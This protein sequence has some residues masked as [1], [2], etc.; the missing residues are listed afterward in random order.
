[1]KNIPNELRAAF[2][3]HFVLPRFEELLDSLAHGS[4]Y[5]HAGD[6]MGRVGIFHGY[7]THSHYPEMHGVTTTLLDSGF[8][9]HRCDFP[10]HGRSVANGC[11]KERGQIKS[12]LRL[13][14]AVHGVTYKTLTTK[15]KKTLPVF[16]VGNSIGA[17]AIVRFLEEYPSVQKYL[18]GVVLIG[19]PL[20]ITQNADEWV[21]KH[22]RLLDP[23]FEFISRIL[24][25]LPVGELPPGDG[26]DPKE[27]NGKITARTAQQMYRSAKTARRKASRIMVPILCIHGAKD[28]TALLSGVEDFIGNVSTPLEKRKLIIYP[29]GGHRIFKRAVH[30]AIPWMEEQFVA[31][32]RVGLNFQ[33]GLLEDTLDSVIEIPAIIMIGMRR[34][35][36][37][38]VRLAIRWWRAFFL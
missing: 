16:L 8:S 4:D 7:S 5:P 3:R 14:H 11:E 6:T 21:K 1:M 27:Y 34:L 36:V 10:Y 32:D 9:V 28:E 17:L 22:E 25:L 38:F 31:S 2:V 20:V 29:D 24:P 19:T 30:D 13:V 15:A 33:E 23:M 18:A 35:C 12:F 26:T 37:V